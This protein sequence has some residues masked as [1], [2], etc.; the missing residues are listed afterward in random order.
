MI[1][2]EMAEGA[3]KRGMSAAC[4]WCERYWEARAAGATDGSCG[5]IACGGPIRDMTFPMYRGPMILTKMCYLCGAQAEAAI[6]IRGQGSVGVCK[7]R[8]RGTAKTCYELAMEQLRRRPG[9]IPV[10]KEFSV[11]ILDFD[12]SMMQVRDDG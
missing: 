5:A 6:E 11:P 10:V 3:I 8:G 7:G 9:P 12:E 1:T 2:A 4:A